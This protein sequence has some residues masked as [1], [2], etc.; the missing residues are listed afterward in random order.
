MMRVFWGR[1]SAGRAP[2]LQAGGHRFDPGRLHT[3]CVAGL[4]QYRG[5]FEFG[6]ST[7]L[8]TVS[9]VGAFAVVLVFVSVNQVLVRLWTRVP[10][11]GSGAMACVTMTRP[12][13]LSLPGHGPLFDGMSDR[14]MRSDRNGSPRHRQRGFRGVV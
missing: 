5:C 2:A 12:S 6:E 14:E 7:S 8:G 4:A 11:T 10:G 3:S 9:R 13:A 1:S